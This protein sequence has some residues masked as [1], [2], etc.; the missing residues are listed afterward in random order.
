MFKDS[1]TKIDTIEPLYLPKPEDQLVNTLDWAAIFK[2]MGA[3]IWA[4]VDGIKHIVRHFS[5]NV[6]DACFKNFFLVKV[7]LWQQN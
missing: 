5:A 3:I 7:R 1:Q 6:T 2:G 4:V